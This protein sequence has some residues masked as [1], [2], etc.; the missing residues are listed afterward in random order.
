[1]HP[2]DAMS[3]SGGAAI[4]GAEPVLS[5]YALMTR[6]QTALAELM[7]LN[8]EVS[9][10]TEA[11]QQ[12]LASIR[13]GAPPEASRYEDVFQSI[14]DLAEKAV[15]EGEIAYQRNAFSTFQETEIAPESNRQEELFRRW[16]FWGYYDFLAIENELHREDVPLSTLLDIRNFLI[17]QR[18]HRLRDA[19]VNVL[20]ILPY[21]RNCSSS[22]QLEGD[23]EL[24]EALKNFDE[25]LHELM[26]CLLY[27]EQTRR[28]FDLVHD[29]LDIFVQHEGLYELTF[30]EK[31]H[32]D[33]I[34]EGMIDKLKMSY[35]EQLVSDDEVIDREPW[36][37][38]YLTSHGILKGLSESLEG[39]SEQG[40]VKIYCTPLDG[41][42]ALK[43]ELAQIAQL[44]GGEELLFEMI[45][46]HRPDKTKD[47]EQ[48]PLYSEVKQVFDHLTAIVSRCIQNQE[49]NQNF[50]RIFEEWEKEFQDS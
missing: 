44:Q 19:Y 15:S 31:E 32:L 22:Y 25:V 11:A 34:V 1:M 10:S 45:E 50:S 29:V 28:E 12:L 47:F 16:R 13:A 43:N 23:I 33:Q 38:L 9:P 17:H 37:F 5:D 48:N 4:P 30:L 35:R 7:R 42:I 24:A 14:A 8:V 6:A 20:S 3:A 46:G 40:A 2:I 18:G 26:G 21:R 41:L 36:L 49:L 27:L 39:I